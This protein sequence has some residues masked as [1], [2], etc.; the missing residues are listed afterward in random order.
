MDCDPTAISAIV[1]ISN[2]D[3][4][5]AINTLQHTNSIIHEKIYDYHIYKIT[6]YCSPKITKNIFGELYNLYNDKHNLMECVDKIRII[7]SD[8]NMTVSNM[9]NGLKNNIMKSNLNIK[10][11]LY[12]IDKFA[13][14]ENIDICISDPD[15]IIMIISSLFYHKKIEN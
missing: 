5:T 1:K 9:L 15:K 6:G 10:T 13:D 12:L 11:K 2:G 7:M 14:S 4:R 8:N 3:M